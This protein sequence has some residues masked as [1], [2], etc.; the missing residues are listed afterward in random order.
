MARKRGR[1]RAGTVELDPDK[2]ERR[3]V[4][5]GLTRNGLC[6][7]AGLS[8]NTVLSAIRGDGVFPET[9]RRIA[10]A[11]EYD[12]VSELI[13][14]HSDATEVGGTRAGDEW[15]VKEYLGG[16]H[17]ASN[18]L[19]YRVCRLR[20]EFVDERQGRGK[21]YDL[22]PL[23]TGA[24]EE[25][26]AHLV[27]HP[28]VCERIGHHRHIAENFNAF[29]ERN[30]DFWWVVDRWVGS[31]TLEAQL[32]QG[33]FPTERLP[34]LMHEIALGLDA[35]HAANVVFRE[36][37][38]SR[39]IL[40]ADD[41]R[42][43]LTDFE[44]AKLVDTGPTVSTSWPDDPY[45]APEVEDATASERSDL[46]SWARVLLRVATGEEL[47]EKGQDGDTLTRVGLPKA[48][49]RVALDCLSPGPSDRPKNVKQVLRATAGWVSK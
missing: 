26:R 9:A 48:V 17:T 23:A 32:Q 24:R 25:M 14:S 43:V 22:E 38:P 49:W 16:W 36:L 5:L 31:T 4:Q 10:K 40:A 6:D 8:R 28:R 3:L 46:Y 35:L 42:A 15:Q 37:A 34:R 12:D 7:K 20:H 41:Q 33:V 44:L 29:P 27:R 47:P 39:V 2:L 18:A 1:K 21:R 13:L 30:E 45:R 19:R 11:L